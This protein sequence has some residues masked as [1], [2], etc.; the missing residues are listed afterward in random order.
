MKSMK[1]QWFTIGHKYAFLEAVKKAMNEDDNGMVRSVEENRGQ[2]YEVLTWIM[3]ERE[4]ER[5]KFKSDFKLMDQ[6]MLL[7]ETRGPILGYFE[8]YQYHKIAIYG[9]GRMRKHLF[10]FVLRTFICHKWM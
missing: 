7:M 9:L 10:L 5:D 1:L 6:W 3:S 4:A 2:E 8:K